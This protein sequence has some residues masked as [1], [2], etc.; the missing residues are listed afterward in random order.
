MSNHVGHVPNIG[1]ADGYVKAEAVN[2]V[3]FKWLSDAVRDGN[4][5][6]SR[7]VIKWPEDTHRPASVNSFGIRVSNAHAI[8]EQASLNHQANLATSYLDV[9]SESTNEEQN[10]ESHLFISELEISIS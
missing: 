4:V 5:E 9:F 8:V 6:T 10:K 7:R 2:A 3:P 1:K